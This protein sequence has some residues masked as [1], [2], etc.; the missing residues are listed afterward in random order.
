MES[1]IYDAMTAAIVNQLEGIRRSEIVDAN[2]ISVTAL[3]KLAHVADLVIQAN[4]VN[5]FGLVAA[6]ENGMLRAMGEIRTSNQRMEVKT[7]SFTGS[8]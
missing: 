2:S 6:V 3:M 7:D 5:K 4:P 8:A 1:D